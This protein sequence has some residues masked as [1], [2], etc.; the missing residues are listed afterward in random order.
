MFTQLLLQSQKCFTCEYKHKN[1]TR[2]K[3][4]CSLVKEIGKHDTFINNFRAEA[5]PCAALTAKFAKDCKSNISAIHCR[6]C[7][8][9]QLC[10]VLLNSI[11]VTSVEIN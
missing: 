4:G 9:G 3:E 7:R 5:P 8:V 11:R 1:N 6:S 10:R 2:N